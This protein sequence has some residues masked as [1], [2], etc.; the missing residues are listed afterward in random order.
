MQVDKVG[1]RR[2]VSVQRGHPFIS[3]HRSESWGPVLSIWP[4]K[5]SGSPRRRGVSPLS[6]LFQLGL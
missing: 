5:D 6:V 2:L 3:G 1:R 4:F